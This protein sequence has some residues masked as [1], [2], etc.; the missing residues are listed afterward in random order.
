MQTARKKDSQA[1]WQFVLY[2]RENLSQDEN[3]VLRFE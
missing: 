1:A 3:L 2:C